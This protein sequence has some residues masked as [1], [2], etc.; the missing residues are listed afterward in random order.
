MSGQGKGKPSNDQ[1]TGTKDP[2]VG[3]SSSH[4]VQSAAKRKLEQVANSSAEELVLL[5]SQVEELSGD[6][7]VIKDNMDGLMQKSDEMMTKADMKAFIKGTVEEIM[8]EINKSIE[9]TI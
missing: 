9:I 3:A 8:I 6:I 4:T 1:K 7:K 5:N 2:K